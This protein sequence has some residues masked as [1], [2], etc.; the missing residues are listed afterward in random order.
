MTKNNVVTVHLHENQ[1][2]LPSIKQRF[3]L[4]FP[5]AAGTPG[6]PSL[7]DEIR[8]DKHHLLFNTGFIEKLLEKIAETKERKGVI[9][10]ASF[11]V[12]HPTV[13]E[14]LQDVDTVIITQKYTPRGHNLVE[15]Y[16]KI[17]CTYPRSAFPGNIIP[18]LV[19]RD[20]QKDYGLIDGVRFFGNIHQ[21]V[22]LVQ[23]EQRAFFHPKVVIGLDPPKSRSK[24]LQSAYLFDG[25]SN[26]S[27]N[28]EHS[29][30]H[31]RL[32]TAREE[33][34][35]FFKGFAH[36]WSLSEGIHNLSIGVES[37]YDWVKKSVV[38]PA[39]PVCTGCG[40]H[41]KMKTLWVPDI[42]NPNNAIQKLVCAECKQRMDFI[43]PFAKRVR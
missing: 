37:R 9:C 14:A 2:P 40:K 19:R 10:I 27:V 32:T 33:V 30:E 39:L 28:A 3:P 12:T 23:N 7:P 38:Y 25:S 15:L 16:G 20:A 29:F 18:H 31:M 1:I 17:G 13:L 35:A 4:S 24:K 41:T 11:I 6:A 26:I 5:F 36:Y 22:R 21:T 34:D 8:I 42:R 43:K